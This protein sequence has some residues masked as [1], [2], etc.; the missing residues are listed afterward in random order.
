MA[1]ETKSHGKTTRW[2]SATA[3]DI[4]DDECISRPRGR[5]A[6]RGLRTDSRLL[7]DH[8]RVPRP[9]VE[10]YCLAGACEAVQGLRV[11]IHTTL[12][13]L[14]SFAAVMVGSNLRCERLEYEAR[15]PCAS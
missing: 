2:T 10:L 11:E 15:E 5:H 7:G 4:A 1:P 8:G 9:E 6:G 12:R 14:C 3:A 13:L